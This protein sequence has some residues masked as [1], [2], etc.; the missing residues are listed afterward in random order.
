MAGRAYVGAKEVFQ[1][2]TYL[3]YDRKTDNLKNKYII[4]IHKPGI[5]EYVNARR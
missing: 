4:Y 3:E 5:Y 1:H 2:T